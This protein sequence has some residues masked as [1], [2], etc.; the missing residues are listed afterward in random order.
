MF[1]DMS[2]SALPP[3]YLTVA[4]AAQRLSVVPNTVRALIAKGELPAT[5]VGDQWLIPAEAVDR[6][7]SLGPRHGRRLTPA[8]AWGLLF[9]GAGLPAPWLTPVER[10]R[11]KQHLVRRRLD[12]LRARLVDRSRPRSLRA[13][14]SML[15]RLRRDPA[16]M[17]TG[18][19]AASELRLGLIGSDRVDA[20]VDGSRVDEVIRSYR[21]RP[22]RD[23]NVTLR[24]VPSFTDAW[25]PAKVAPV[26][27]IALDLLDDPD[28]RAQQLGNELLA[29]IGS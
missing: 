15:D 6:R 26:S 24:V 13:H 23:A 28:P 10:W 29:R 21:L 2:A 4:E 3:G 14:P 16:L 11:M 8:G 18:V 20:Y 17:I 7:L 22:S 27:A 5:K 9:L 25:P 12:D 19:T 1:D